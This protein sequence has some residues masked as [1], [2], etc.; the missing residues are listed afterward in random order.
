MDKKEAK[1]QYKET[2]QPM[3][4]YQIKNLTNGK[5]FIGSATHIH[6]RI[7][8]IKFQLKNGVYPN[9]QIQNEYS[10]TGESHFSIEV[11]DILS[12]TK[13]DPRYDYKE[14]LQ[15]LEEMWLQRVQPFGDNG[16]NTT[17]EI[18]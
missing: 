1:R 3:G 15:I 9:K 2:I 8:R 12:P 16:Y 11:L 6:A 7:N 4:V 13:E 14:E 10:E 5:I 18:G 17:G